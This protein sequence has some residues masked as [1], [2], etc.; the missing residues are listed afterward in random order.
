MTHTHTHTHHNTQCSIYK[1]AIYRAYTDA[2][3]ATRVAVANYMGI[4]GPLI[5]AEVGEEVQIIFRNKLTFPVNLQ[6]HGV[7]ESSRLNKVSG[8][9]SDRIMMNL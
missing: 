5:R 8:V 2:T 6:L 4:L 3:F 7:V 9:E 1:K